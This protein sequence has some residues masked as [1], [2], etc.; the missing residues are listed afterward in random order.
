[1]K[2]NTTQEKI[3]AYRKA[4]AFLKREIKIRKRE[5]TTTFTSTIQA[6]TPTTKIWNNI[7]RFCGNVTTNDKNQIANLLAQD[8]SHLSKD[9]N[10]SQ[11]FTSHKYNTKTFN[12]IPT[13][14]ALEIDKPITNIELTIALKSTTPGINRMSYPMI[15]HSSPSIKN[16]ILS[17]FNHI[18]NHYIPQSNKTS[19]IIPI[20]KPQK[21][22]TDI[23]SFRPISLNCCL[24]K[25]MDKIIANRLWWFLNNDKLLHPHRI[26]FKK[27]KST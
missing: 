6:N 23:S 1:L 22:K 14:S 7:R 10:F 20:L 18:F 17:H 15:K 27:G 21:D 25:T 12:H 26:G 3:I 5:S 11:E 24:S 13:T 16:R 19:L 4:N 2:R 8:W 9:A